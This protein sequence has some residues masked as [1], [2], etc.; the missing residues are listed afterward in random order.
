[1]DKLLTQKELAEYLQ[2]TEVTL[3]KWRKK[4]M[5]Y[6]KAGKSVRYDKDQVMRW[7]E[8]NKK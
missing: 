1:M 2:V 5:P 7:L 6:V 3:W 8:E 4:G